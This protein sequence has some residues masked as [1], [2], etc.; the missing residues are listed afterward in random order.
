MKPFLEKYWTWI[1]GA[2]GLIVLFRS[3]KVATNSSFYNA[4][5]ANAAPF[6]HAGGAQAS[7]VAGSAGTPAL[8]YLSGADTQ[9][10]TVAGVTSVSLKP[11][12]Q[13]GLNAGAE[14]GSAAANYLNRATTINLGNTNSYPYTDPVTG[15]PRTIYIHTYWL[16]IDDPNDGTG[17]STDNS[18]SILIYD[19]APA[20]DTF[21]PIPI[22]DMGG[23]DTPPQGYTAGNRAF[24]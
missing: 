16:Y 11:A 13:T 19:G 17:S 14:N 21:S 7:G 24:S 4:Q 15:A 22:G 6:A 9:T 18:G 8:S 20:D 10:T 3:Y 5:T 23:S 1:A 12:T 2:F